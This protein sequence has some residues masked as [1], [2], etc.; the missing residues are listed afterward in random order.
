MYKILIR[1]FLLILTVVVLTLAYISYF[2][3]ETDKF[4]NIIK[5]KAN[6]VNRYAA[7]DFKKTKIY[8][9]PFQ[10]DLVVKLQ[11]PKILI[12]KNELFLSRL[13]LFLPIKS[14]FNS[15]FLLK[16]AEIAFIENDIK[17]LTKITKVY[18]PKIV[19]K[20]IN[21]IF[22]KGTISGEFSI[23]FSPNGDIENNYNFSGKIKNATLNLTSDFAIKNLTTEI[24]QKKK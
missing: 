7:L 8:L 24:I 19:N 21:K 17:D 10:L 9:N 23:P 2:G 16:K 4:D 20:R 22:R 3:I 12:K 5:E 13:H 18:L 1:F 11:N 15:D 6:S 14:F